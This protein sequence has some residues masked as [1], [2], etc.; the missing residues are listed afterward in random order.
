MNSS[1][2][3]RITTF[4]I[5]RSFSWKVLEITHMQD[6]FFGN[7]GLTS[8]LF[9][10]S[11]GRGYLYRNTYWRHSG[12]NFLWRCASEGLLSPYCSSSVYAT[13]QSSPLSRE[14]RCVLSTVFFTF[15][16]TDTSLQ[17]DLLHAVATVQLEELEK[18]GMRCHKS[19]DHRGVVLAL[20][21]WASSDGL[22]SLHSGSEERM[23]EI[24]TLYDALGKAMSALARSPRIVED[25]PLLQLFGISTRNKGRDAYEDDLT[26]HRNSFIYSQALDLR[27]ASRNLDSNHELHSVTAPKYAVKDLVQAR[28]LDQLRTIISSVEGLAQRP[29]VLRL[30][31]PWGILHRTP[32]VNTLY[33]DVSSVFRRWAMGPPGSFFTRAAMEPPSPAIISLTA[34]KLQASIQSGK[35]RAYSSFGTG[36]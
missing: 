7:V 32:G 35:Q 29:R 28:L 30:R 27:G 12:Q 21:N 5:N 9:V 25:P 36:D 1:S 26:V 34:A 23:E 15:N 24:S 3:W 10:N 16:I 18:H 19:S 4:E 13:R 33:P 8:P 14:P 11:V 20:Y 6:S 17:V 2:S 31:S 22:L